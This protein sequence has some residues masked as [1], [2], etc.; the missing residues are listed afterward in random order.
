MSKL[1]LKDISA[2]MRHM[3]ICMMVTKTPNGALESRPMSNNREVEYD[4]DSYFFTDG[5]FPVAKQIEADAQVNLAF[6]HEP[7]LG[8][9]LYISVTGKGEVIRDKAEMKKH[10]VKDVEV[11]FKDGIDTPGIAMIHV[12]AS[13]IT[14]WNGKEEG[15]IPLTQARAA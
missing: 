11:Y 7:T 13:N 8:K 9:S 3:D 6:M 5:N 1:T 4:G 15:D 10:W 12:K 14:Y 2:A